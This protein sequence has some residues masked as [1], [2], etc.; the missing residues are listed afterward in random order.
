MTTIEKAKLAKFKL[1]FMALMLVVDRKDEAT[2]AYEDALDAVK[3]II[4]YEEGLR[5]RQRLDAVKEIIG[6]ERT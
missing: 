3:Q 5:E 4:A 1:E 2:S 6:E